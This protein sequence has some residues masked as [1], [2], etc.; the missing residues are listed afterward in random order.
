MGN[1]NIRQKDYKIVQDILNE[2]L[3]P[4][5]EVYLFGSRVKGTARRGSDLDIAIEAGRQLTFKELT[6]LDIAFNES[7]LPYKVDILDYNA[8]KEP[9]KS[10]IRK[11]FMLFS[12]IKIDEAN[13]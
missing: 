5:A 8:C 2:Y 1:I 10:L 7:D 9:F 3:P 6:D 13:S 11:D 12:E 4:K